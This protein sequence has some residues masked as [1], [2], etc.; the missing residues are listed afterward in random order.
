MDNTQKK[1]QETGIFQMNF[2]AYQSI[3]AINRSTLE[4]LHNGS[5]AH[6]LEYMTNRPSVTPALEVGSAIHF[7]CLEP[8]E[9]KKQVVVVKSRSAGAKEANKGKTLILEGDLET[10][11]GI[12]A[13]LHKNKVIFEGEEMTAAQLIATSQI[14]RSLVWR[15]GPSGALCKARPDLIK[16]DAII[17][18]KTCSDIPDFSRSAFNFG[19]HRQASYY[20]MGYSNACQ[21]MAMDFYFLCAEKT[22]PYGVRMF[23]ASTDFLKRG[24]EDIRK[25]L[26]TFTECQKTNSWPGYPLSTEILDLPG[27]VR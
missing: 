12:K 5:P 22:A 17:D 3:Q 26:T 24:D 27:W 21:K 9:F 16:G 2:E 23:Q 18:F 11:E 15:D 6:A 1:M 14:E 4:V 19:Y 8:D 20:L 7:A 13:S 10:I 25:A